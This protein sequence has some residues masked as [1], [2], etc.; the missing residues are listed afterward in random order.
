MGELRDGEMGGR[1][2][3]YMGLRGFHFL[4]GVDLCIEVH[5]HGDLG[6]IGS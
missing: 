6:L 2:M 4:F 5:D 3:G 1:D